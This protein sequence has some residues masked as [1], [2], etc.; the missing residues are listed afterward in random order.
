MHIFSPPVPQ[1]VLPVELV[2]GVVGVAVV[3]ELHE[4]V[5][6]LHGDLPQAPVAPEE[7]FDVPLAGAVAQPANVH[8]GG[9]HFGSGFG[10]W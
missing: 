9:G 7:L 2:A 1:E 10:G 6:V 8:A 4:A 3:L 5:A